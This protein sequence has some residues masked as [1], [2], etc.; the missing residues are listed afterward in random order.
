MIYKKLQNRGITNI[1][2]PS[3]CRSTD[4]NLYIYFIIITLSNRCGTSLRMPFFLDVLILPSLKHMLKDTN[5]HSRIKWRITLKKYRLLLNHIVLIFNLY[6]LLVLNYRKSKHSKNNNNHTWQQIHV[7]KRP[8]RDAWAKES[9][10]TGFLK[11]IAFTFYRAVKEDLEAFD[12]L[13]D[14]VISTDKTFMERK[15]EKLV[16]ITNSAYNHQAIATSCT[17]LSGRFLPIQI[18]Y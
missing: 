15:N 5:C 13:E 6:T 9:V 2:L 17:T 3:F 8:C 14:L 12:I 7:K 18:V 11:E 10:S 4:K 16:S 1:P